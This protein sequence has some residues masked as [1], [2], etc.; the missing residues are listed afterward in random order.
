MKFAQITG[1][2]QN[3]ILP[4]VIALK[5]E[6]LDRFKWNFAETFIV[7]FSWSLLKMG[8]FG[9]KLTEIW[10][11][12]EKMLLK[13]GVP[14][15]YLGNRKTGLD[16]KDCPTVLDRY[17]GSQGKWYLNLACPTWQVPFKPNN[18]T[19]LHCLWQFEQNF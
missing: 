14:P 16:I 18:Y 2:L 6:P 11:F 12:F 10:R 9:W 13:K 8:T 7:L 19:Y 1:D 17:L 3:K 4:P 5:I 15:N